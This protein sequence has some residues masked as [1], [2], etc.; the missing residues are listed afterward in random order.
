MLAAMPKPGPGGAAERRLVVIVQ[1]RC[2]QVLY[3]ESCLGCCPGM[4]LA[5]GPRCWCRAPCSLCLP[6][7]VMRTLP[8]AAQEFVLQAVDAGQPDGCCLAIICGTYPARTHPYSA[9]IACCS[10]AACCTAGQMAQ[11]PGLRSTGE[12]DFWDC[13]AADMQR[14]RLRVPVPA[15]LV[16]VGGRTRQRAHF[17]RLFRWGAPCTRGPAMAVNGGGVQVQA[18]P[19]AGWGALSQHCPSVRAGLYTSAG[20]LKWQDCPVLACAAMGGAFVRI[21][22]LTHSIPGGMGCSESRPSHP[23][24]SVLLLMMSDVG[25]SGNE[26]SSIGIHRTA[27]HP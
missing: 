1:F 10:C 8:R 25:V 12:S 15:A 22:Y 26:L 5:A 7:A 4:A 14:L 24:A 20:R 19:A 11:A 13:K 17:R 27:Q 3:Q 9:G 6:V 23:P 16:L 2:C 18:C 21:R